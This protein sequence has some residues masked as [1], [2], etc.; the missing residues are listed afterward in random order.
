MPSRGAALAVGIAVATAAA[1]VLWLRRLAH[2]AGMGRL[3]RLVARDALELIGETPMIE[4]RT[5]S[6][7]T[8]CRVLAK[9]EF[10]NPGG[11]SKDRVARAIISEAEASGALREGGTVVEA[12]AGSTG[13]PGRAYPVTAPAA[14]AQSLHRGR[15]FPLCACH[16]PLRPPAPARPAQASAWPW[17]APRVDTSATW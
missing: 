9:A 8:G 11:S 15:L 1:A 16:P 3:R 10:L 12:T 5:L 4:L 2:T 13:G 7:Q 6:R 14:A 17:P